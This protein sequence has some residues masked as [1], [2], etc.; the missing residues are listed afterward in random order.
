MIHL[1]NDLPKH[2]IDE[3]SVKIFEEFL[4]HIMLTHYQQ[5]VQ[6]GHHPIA[7]ASMVNN[8]ISLYGRLFMTV[9]QCV[10]AN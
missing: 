4:I 8:Q 2:V 9:L 10:K 1:Y 6:F 5:G 3:S 7:D